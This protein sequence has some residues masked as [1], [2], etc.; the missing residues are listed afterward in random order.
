MIQSYVYLL[1]VIS[2]GEFTTML[3]KSLDHMQVSQI[4]WISVKFYFITLPPESK[5]L[6]G[7]RL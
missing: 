1:V 6:D 4:N 7:C 5:L 2:E 3:C